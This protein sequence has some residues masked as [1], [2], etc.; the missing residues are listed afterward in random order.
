MCRMYKNCKL[1]HGDLSEFNLLLSEGKVVYVIDVSQSMDLS[2]PRNLH[3]LIRDIENVLAFFRR[4]DI[5]DLPTPITL[6]NT[7]TDLAMS[8]ESSLIVQVCQ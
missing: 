2:H 3:Y 7:I 1:V 4:L 8:E 5:P 6:F